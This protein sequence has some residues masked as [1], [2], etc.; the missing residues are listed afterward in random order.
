MVF[1][2]GRYDKGQDFSP[3]RPKAIELRLSLIGKHN[4]LGRIKSCLKTQTK[5]KCSFE[6]A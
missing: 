4:D 6:H 2:R 1:E 3:M 5:L